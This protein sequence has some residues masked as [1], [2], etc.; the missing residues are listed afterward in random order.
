MKNFQMTADE[1]KVNEPVL[2][3][4]LRP[5]CACRKKGENFQCTHFSACTYWR[6][7]N[8][9]TLKNSWLDRFLRAF[10]ATRIQG[11][12]F[13]ESLLDAPTRQ[14]VLFTPFEG[15]RIMRDLK[16]TIYT[17]QEKYSHPMALYIEGYK[18]R[19]IADIL[20]ISFVSVLMRIAY[21]RMKLLTLIQNNPIL[22]LRMPETENSQNK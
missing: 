2:S 17:L 8:E 13:T 18:M 11:R 1:K 20:E 9:R 12:I 22:T 3:E 4:E 14:S 10:V 19:E 16:K 6:K 7:L 5:F 15:K 21:A